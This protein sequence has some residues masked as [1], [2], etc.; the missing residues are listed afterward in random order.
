[1]GPGLGLQE[2]GVQGGEA[3]AQARVTAAV[4]VMG[5][6]VSQEGVGFGAGGTWAGE[7]VGE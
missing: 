3:A 4:G 5:D 2:G 1:M 6:E 7:P